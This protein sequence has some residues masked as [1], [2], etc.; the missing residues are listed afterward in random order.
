MT[1][2]QYFDRASYAFYRLESNGEVL[3]LSDGTTLLYTAHLQELISDLALPLLPSLDVLLLLIAATRLEEG[4]FR[5]LVQAPI[6]GLL[7]QWT[8]TP[9][10]FL[11]P[12]LIQQ[13]FQ[14]GLSLTQLPIT[15]RTGE[16]RLYLLQTLLTETPNTLS[17]ADST[18]ILNYLMEYGEALNHYLEQYTFLLEPIEE[19]VQ[20]INQV[21]V[22]PI[23]EAL[24]SFQQWQQRYSTPA[25]LQQAV[26]EHWQLV[27]PKTLPE[28]RIAP[29]TESAEAPDTSWHDQLLEEAEA[30][31]IVT[32][33]PTLQASLRLPQTPIYQQKRS[34][35]GVADLS[36]KGQFD[37]LLLSEHAYDTDIFLSRLVNQ[38]ALYRQREGAPQPPKKQR[39]VLLDVSIQNWGTAKV[40]G[41]AIA[42]ALQQGEAPIQAL[43]AVGQQAHRLDWSSQQGFMDSLGYVSPNLDARHGLASFLEQYRPSGLVE[44]V[45]ISAQRAQ[46]EAVQR[47]WANHPNALH[48]GI[49]TT[50]EGGIRVVQYQPQYQVLQNIRLDLEALWRKPKTSSKGHLPQAQPDAALPILAPMRRK[51]RDVQHS[52]SG[53]LFVLTAQH[54][55]LCYAGPTSDHHFVQKGWKRLLKAV[56]DGFL[57]HVGQ[58]ANGEFILLIV[59]TSSYRLLLINV[60]TG[61]R[62]ELERR[63][64]RRLKL[65]AIIFQDD[66]FYVLGARQA[67]WQIE[68]DPLTMTDASSQYTWA[69]GLARADD[70]FWEVRQ[71]QGAPKVPHN[72]L[73]RIQTFQVAR[74]PQLS[75]IINQRHFLTF[76][77][78]RVHWTSRPHATTPEFTRGAQRLERFRFRFKSGHTVTFHKLGYMVLRYPQ[79]ETP[80]IYVPLTI[81]RDLG[82]ATES[83]FTGN[84]YFCPE[85]A[86]SIPVTT[87]FED[88]FQPWVQ[89]VW[90]ALV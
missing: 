84:A 59:Q 58:R 67:C 29:L 44:L 74:T 1:V 86:D 43:Y 73:Q 46:S 51:F 25:A 55:L 52:N 65:E 3:V 11:E 34:L 88:H 53:H 26:E 90:D 16:G 83:S 9:S 85:G 27:S 64:L 61:E 33:V 47:L 89:S 42:W 2:G 87:F 70:Q 35:G 5:Q 38:E 57:W 8:D 24:A 49:Y 77:D 10:D 45:W 28:D 13:A 19:A 37:Q 54:D 23:Y 36:N 56:P 50:A 7:Q 75:V 79:S 48:H 41:Y 40:L 60:Q 63:D 68:V 21:K 80:L 31:P 17:Q 81:N 14:F 39:M 78:N 18:A 66:A 71:P 4:P 82:L 30:V 69:K 12:Q 20:Y 76:E 62:Q 32:L 15:F 72:L 22:P 6:E